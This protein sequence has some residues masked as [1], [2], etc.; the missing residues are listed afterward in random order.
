MAFTVGICP[1]EWGAQP[2]GREEYTAQN[3]S[4]CL[5]LGQQQAVVSL[6]DAAPP[7]LMLIPGEGALAGSVALFPRDVSGGELI[8]SVEG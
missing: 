7:A 8:P 6:P 1:L 3:E 2:M 4:V 5:I